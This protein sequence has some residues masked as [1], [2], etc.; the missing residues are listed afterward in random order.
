MVSIVLQDIPIKCSQDLCVY[1]EMTVAR[2]MCLKSIRTKKQT[3]CKI[4][5][6]ELI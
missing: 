5:W 4:F 1:E 3:P 6:P 2:S